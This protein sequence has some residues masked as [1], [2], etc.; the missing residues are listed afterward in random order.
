MA[1]YRA[2]VA[3]R[4]AD[5]E[6]E[7]RAALGET[8]V[9]SLRAICKRL[10]IT[11]PFMNKHFPAVGR[12][13]VEQHRRCLSAETAHRHELLSHDIHDIAAELQ[14]LGLY[15]SVPRIVERIPEGSRREWKTITLAVREARKALGICE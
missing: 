11:V 9:P 2:C 8:P 3:K 12:M 7:A 4:R 13:I 14:S 10:D 1:Q 15:P 5:L 6:R